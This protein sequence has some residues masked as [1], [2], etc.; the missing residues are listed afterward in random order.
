M[1][2]QPC[3]PLVSVTGTISHLQWPAD[4][5]MTFFPSYK[6]TRDCTH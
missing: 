1:A 3:N 6:W 2:L 4:P 5:E